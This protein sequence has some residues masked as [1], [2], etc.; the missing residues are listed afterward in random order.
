MANSLTFLLLYLIFWCLATFIVIPRYIDFLYK[1]NLGKKI[2]EEWLIG[3]ATEFSRLHKNK[4]GTPTMGW[5]V[6]LGVILFMV[7][8]SV[9]I[10]YFAP[11]LWLNINHSLLSRNETYLA[12]F[13]LFTVGWIGLVDDYLNIREIWRTKGLSARVKLIL[14]FLFGALWAYW[15]YFKLGYTE[16]RIPLLG[17]FDLGIW[18]V[19]LFVLIIA[20]M[21]NSVNITDGLDGLAGW[22]LLFNYGVYAFVCYGQDL[23]ILSALCLIICGSL[24]GFLWFNI[25]PAA[26]YM[27]DLWSLSLG[28][29]LAIMAMMTDTLVVLLITSAIFWLELISVI[30]QLLSKKFRNGKKIF[31]IAPF[32][33]HLEAI[34]WSE[35]NIVMRFWLV[36]MI[37]AILGGIVSQLI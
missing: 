30:I 6:I 23:Y 21:A 14:L 3:K 24:I 2:R 8:V 34:G 28:A 22:L 16:V 33:H 7:S 25:K 36:W 20:T 27:G 19:P 15:F 17:N 11:Q 31:R 18:Y 4:I 5:W 32:H 35:E 13:T 26:F 10:Q 29:T 1:H 37:L 12:L 9:V